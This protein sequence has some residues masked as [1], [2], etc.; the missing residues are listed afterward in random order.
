MPGGANP[1]APPRVRTQSFRALVDEVAARLPKNYPVYPFSRGQQKLDSGPESGIYAVREYA[2]TLYDDLI[3]NQA[4]LSQET[5]D[6]VSNSL[7]ITPTAAPGQAQ[8]T[9]D[10]V[11]GGV[12]RLE[13]WYYTASVASA[14]RVVV[15]DG[16]QRG[17]GAV[18]PS[19]LAASSAFR[20]VS[21][22]TE[23]SVEFTAESGTSTVG[24]EGT[25]PLPAWVRTM[26][27]FRVSGTDG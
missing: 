24:M 22:W 10:T 16:D 19:Q 1:D 12:Y 17:F 21:E 27:I 5:I 7:R 26:T 23:G 14:G 11:A 15:Y 6:G 2:G 3:G 13:Y 20:S 9:V 4:T 25:N 8:I 18:E